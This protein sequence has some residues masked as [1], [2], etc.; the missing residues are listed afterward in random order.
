[1]P[2]MKQLFMNAENNVLNSLNSLSKEI[3]KLYGYVTIAG[4]NFGEPAINSVPCGPFA[5]A[6]YWVFWSVFK[7]HWKTDAN[8]KYNMGQY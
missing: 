1:M 7:R 5:N 4:D 6:F 2:K 3:N 8:I